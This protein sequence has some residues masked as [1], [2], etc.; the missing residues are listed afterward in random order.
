[1]AITRRE[2][3]T[4]VAKAGVPAAVALT[5]GSKALQAEEI[6][7]P[8]AAVGLLY[9]ASICIG[10]KACEAACCRGQQYSR[11]Y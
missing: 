3:F 2:L 5:V 4:T 6:P 10:C 1:V 7:V 9:D 11:G 8:S